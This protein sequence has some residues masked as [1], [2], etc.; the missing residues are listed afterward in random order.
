MALLASL[1]KR[2]AAP[3]AAALAA[4][5]A[6]VAAAAVSPVGAAIVV[7][8]GAATVP[9]IEAYLAYRLVYLNLEAI[10]AAATSAAD[11]ARAAVAHYN[12]LSARA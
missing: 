7:A 8:G 5:V 2:A 10:Y 6:A 11:K 12:A 1:S 3:A 4:L 9:A